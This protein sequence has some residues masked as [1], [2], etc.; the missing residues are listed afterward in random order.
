MTIKY[1]VHEVAKDFEVS[2]KEVLD[3]LAAH[4]EGEKKSM[5]ALE[6]NELDVVFDILTAK[7]SVKNLK[8]YLEDGKEVVYTVKRGHVENELCLKLTRCG[9]DIKATG[10]YFIGID[11]IKEF[12]LAVQ[13]N[14]KM[15][16]GFEIDYIRMLNDALCEP[17]N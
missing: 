4:C 12:D 8:E 9:D 3:I 5:T 15:N 17:E 7:H 13:L 16:D 14:P 1:R 11:W 2:S 6:E 10:S